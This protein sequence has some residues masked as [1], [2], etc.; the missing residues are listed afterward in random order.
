MIK[1][2]ATKFVKEYLDFVAFSEYTNWYMLYLRDCFLFI[3]WWN[4]IQHLVCL[5]IFVDAFIEK[6]MI[7]LIGIMRENL[8]GMQQFFISTLRLQKYFVHISE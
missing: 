3:F 2:Q 5:F 7:T 4:K 1:A 6:C 8:V